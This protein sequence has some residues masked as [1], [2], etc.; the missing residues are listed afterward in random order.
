MS[1]YSTTIETTYANLA[2]NLASATV[3][4]NIYIT[5]PANIIINSSSTSGS[6]GY[7]FKNNIKSGVLFDLTATE[8]EKSTITAL[9]YAFEGCT[10]IYAIGALP[11]NKL[12]VAE[13]LYKDCTALTKV[14]VDSLSYIKD[15]SYMFKNCSSLVSIKVNDLIDV[16]ETDE[17]FSGCTSLVSIDIS[18]FQSVTNA[19]SMFSGDTALTTLT[20]SQGFITD[21]KSST[22]LLS[23]CTA[24]TK[25]NRDD[26]AKIDRHLYVRGNTEINGPL[27]VSD[28]SEKGGAIIRGTLEVDDIEILNKLGMIKNSYHSVSSDDSS[29]AT[30]S[31]R[32][33]STSGTL[34]M[35]STSDISSVQSASFNGSSNTSLIT[36][37]PNQNVNT[38]SD[39]T[40]NS[41]TSSIS[42]GADWKAQTLLGVL[43]STKRILLLSKVD[44]ANYAIIGGQIL[45]YNN[46]V[47]ESSYHI[48]LTNT[49]SR[50]FIGASIRDTKA[51]LCTCFYNSSQYYAIYFPGTDVAN[52]YF[53]G[54]NLTNT[55]TSVPLYSSY[56]DSDLTTI[57]NIVD[58]ADTGTKT[59]TEPIDS[60]TSASDIASTVTTLPTTGEDGTP[61]EIV[62]TG[63]LTAVQL[64]ALAESLKEDSDI[65]VN[66]DLS[67]ATV[68]NDATTWTSTNSLETAF[69]SCL[70]LRSFKMPHG[71][72]SISKGAFAGSLFL[73]SLTLNNELT[74]ITG[75]N[76]T[77]SVS[78]FVGYTRLRTLTIP[79]SLTNFGSYTFS[80]SNLRTIYIPSGNNAISSN[81]SQPWQ[82]YSLY[83]TLSS[84]KIYVAQDY[85][86]YLNNSRHWWY[87]N[88][89]T[90]T[91]IDM[92]AHVVLDTTL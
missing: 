54:W 24:L 28:A 49:G 25:I 52:V 20:V 72:T 3:S 77:A 74:S 42:G 1:Q 85:Y 18:M 5:D 12:T 92:S 30:T 47:V 32:A 55:S 60:N 48:D 70:S 40:F 8:T 19:V 41:I 56:V 69:T 65:Q 58:E 71:V 76:G 73:Q 67:G 44:S 88:N 37:T 53:T 82:W 4:S 66:V 81:V 39:V 38:T 68:A 86:N 75:T 21:L 15:A 87:L 91:G 29:H 46:G 22:G 45:E 64:L 14:D 90:H 59:V 63:T 16:V 7:I 33:D 79:Q 13:G 43:S 11:D 35:S 89:N 83:D 62:M 31:D 51:N 9:S 50:S 84:L 10:N 34:T 17:M 26:P 61:H 27:I 78:G 6:L 23:G 2:E 57:V 80:Y 36:F